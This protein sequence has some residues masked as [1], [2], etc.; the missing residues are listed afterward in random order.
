MGS[1][2]VTVSGSPSS[3]AQLGLQPYYVDWTQNGP[4]VNGNYFAVRFDRYGT[5]QW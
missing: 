3:E 4:E 1:Q 2:T 5:L